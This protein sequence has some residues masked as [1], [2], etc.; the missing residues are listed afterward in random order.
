AISALRSAYWRGRVQDFQGNRRWFPA[1]CP[2]HRRGKLFFGR[3]PEFLIEVM[4]PLHLTRH[5]RLIGSISYRP[6]RRVGFIVRR[7]AETVVR[8]TGETIERFHGKI[9]GSGGSGTTRNR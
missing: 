1:R 8:L 2:C 7:T 9:L 3:D 5:F 6:P 4:V